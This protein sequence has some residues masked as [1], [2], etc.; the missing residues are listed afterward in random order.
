MMALKILINMQTHKSKCVV[1]WLCNSFFMKNKLLK[2]FSSSTKPNIC[3]MVILTT[4]MHSFNLWTRMGKV[5]IFSHI[6]VTKFTY[7]N[8]H[9]TYYKKSWLFKRL[10]LM[11]MFTLT[12]KMFVLTK[13]MGHERH[14]VFFIKMTTLTKC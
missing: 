12:K 6:Q 4:F 2:V 1:N 11:K 14:I 10:N 5:L 7:D 3:T 8:S 9:I 13:G